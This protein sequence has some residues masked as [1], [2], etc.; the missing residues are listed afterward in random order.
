MSLEEQLFSA[1]D[2]DA[3]RA[4]ATEIAPDSVPLNKGL[5]CVQYARL[6]TEYQQVLDGTVAAARGTF[7]VFSMAASRT[8]A[9]ALCD[10]V[11]SACVAALIVISGRRHEF[12]PEHD[13]YATVLT[14]D[15]WS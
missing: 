10:A 12:D 1:L 4:L 11:E 14:V 2:V 7:E 5:P 3:V 9:E 8:D 13:L 15:V 6:A